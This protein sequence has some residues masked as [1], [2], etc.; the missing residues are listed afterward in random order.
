MSTENTIKKRK[1]QEV[2][3]E[4]ELEENIIE[5][6]AET[7]IDLFTTVFIEQGSKSVDREDGAAINTATKIVS[8]RKEKIDGTFSNNT[9]GKLIKLILELIKIILKA[10]GENEN[11]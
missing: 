8:K 5:T 11:N 4:C 6:E 9:V 2:K 10:N 1:L 7:F 3:E